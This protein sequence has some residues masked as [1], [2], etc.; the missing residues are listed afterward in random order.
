[1][2][3]RA[4]TFLV[5]V[6]ALTS[7]EHCSGQTTT[8]GSTTNS[9]A[10]E[11]TTTPTTTTTGTTTTSD[12]PTTTPTGPTTTPDATASTPKQVAGIQPAEVTDG[13]PKGVFEYTTLKKQKL[14][15]K[16]NPDSIKNCANLKDELVNFHKDKNLSNVEG[17]KCLYLS[18]GP[19]STNTSTTTAAP[20]APPSG[21]HL[22][23]VYTAQY[24]NVDKKNETVRFHFF[25]NN[26]DPKGKGDVVLLMAYWGDANQNKNLVET[27][28][29]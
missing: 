12:G 26:L 9:A 24:T 3:F 10:A 13:K 15:I 22:R 27:P 8:P 28:L 25:N 1:M 14:C 19:S 16:G 17:G 5:T 29:S 18:E 20:G 21:S 6:L 2:D 7:V 4:L 23:C 11:I